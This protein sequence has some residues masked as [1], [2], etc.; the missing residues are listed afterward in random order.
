M[1]VMRARASARAS[2]IALTI[3]TF[4]GVAATARAEMFNPFQRPKTKGK[5]SEHEII[6][7]APTDDHVLKL[8]ASIFDN[9][10]KKSKYNFVMFYAPWDGH[11][12]AFM[13]R[14]MSYAQ[15]HKMAGTEMTFSLVDATKERDL[16]KRF[17][18]EEY[19]TLIL[20]RD[21]VP[22][23]YV[24]DRSPQHLDKFVRRNLLKPARWL[25]GTDD[26][27]VFL[28]G[29]DVTVIGFFDNKDDL[30]VYHHAAAEFDLDF[31]ETKSKIATEDWKAP[32]PTIKMW[33]DFDKEPVRYPGGVVQFQSLAQDLTRA[34]GCLGPHPP[35]AASSSYGLVDA[36]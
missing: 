26:V 20:F 24:G 19:P 10:L 36:E 34:V 31:G 30:D 16:D 14:W 29:R 8:D 15:S 22:K 1:A 33:R 11:S 17:E 21:G 3:V 27:E 28:M 12:K 35:A 13:P 18:I 32:F 23:R 5:V 9:E 7:E 25:E 4:V 2:A 6:A